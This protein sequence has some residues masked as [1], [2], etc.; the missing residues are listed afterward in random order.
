MGMALKSEFAE[1]AFDFWNEWSI[2]AES[3]DPKASRDVWKSIKAGG[4]ITIATLFHEAKANGWEDSGAYQKPSPEE[5]AARQKKANEAAL[6]E[7]AKIEEAQ[8]A[9]AVQAAE[10]WGQAALAKSHP[11]LI[12]KSIKAHGARLNGE[13]LA[14]P[15]RNAHGKL[16][17]LQFIQP[18]GS[19]KYLPGG[20]KKGGYFSI[21]RPDGVLCL[22]E[23][24][25]TGA[26]IHEVTGY[27]VAV[28]FDA[29]NLKPV[30]LALRSKLPDISILIC[31]DDDWQKEGNPG[32]TKAREA[33]AA[34]GGRVAL[35][36]F[37]EGR[38]D[39]DSDFNDM[40]R[41]SGG[42]AVKAVITA[43]LVEDAAVDGAGEENKPDKA[44]ANDDSGWP[45]PHPLPNTLKFV[46][47]FDL[48][49]LPGALRS[50]VADISE[51]MQ[52]PPDFPAVGAMVALSSVIGR[53]VCI[54][55]KR[56]D[57]WHVIPNLWGVVVGRPGV[58]K[59]PALSEVLKPLDRMQNRATE[60]YQQSQ[61]DMEIEALLQKMKTQ[62]VK[63]DA[64]KKVQEEMEGD[65]RALLSGLM[66]AEESPPLRRYKETD[67]SVEALGELLIENPW[68]LLAYRDELHGLLCSLDKEGQEGARSFYLQGYDGNQGY[69]FDRIG[70]GKNLTIP[71]VCIA[72]LG[73][74]QPGK[75][76]A[77]IHEAVT[78]GAGDD[79]LLQRFGMLVWPDVAGEWRNVDRF[80]DTPAKQAA[81]E[82]F[83]RL[84]ALPPGTDD[85]GNPAPCIYRFTPEAQD[86]FD[87]WRNRLEVSLRA[88]TRH[89]A[90]ESHFSKYRKLIPALSLICALVSQENEVS[91]DSLARALAWSE[92][93]QT[94]ATRAYS[95]GT[96]V[97]T[98]PARA[99]LDKI[100]AGKVNNGFFA[101]EIYFK[102]WS[103][104]NTPEAVKT[105]ATLLCDAGYLRRI[106]SSQGG[107]GGRP[108]ASYLIHPSLLG[109]KK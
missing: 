68:G 17:S 70:R 33:A 89:P 88:G 69:T 31:A 7:Q 54:A 29:G 26:S 59:S 15:I 9:A 10:I 81:F 94:H 75:L 109:G 84:D 91:A 56:H 87:E 63:K 35:P 67:S 105:A 90:L 38:T 45:E 52:C 53:K 103:G 34:I 42:E 107:T 43:A 40:A 78:G 108:T 98:E 79:G 92:Y 55:P 8:A 37:P 51:R 39:G 22:C 106:E 41:L 65:A 82:V 24:F 76:Q 93:L 85:D 99:L 57:D 97:Q 6:L 64:G 62:K 104:L 80:P 19:K 72:M 11:Y 16:Q 83:E 5:I 25:A 60:Q 14:L 58:M 61:K 101:R 100:R 18:D 1:N 77:Y 12:A 21:G 23:G 73:G 46:A 47:P 28:A 27:A 20:K 102:G 3:Y 4:G 96:G 13:A 48:L 36:V 30:A 66:E 2:G 32:L 74:I 95:A 44:K 49:M 86:M 71:A 50:W